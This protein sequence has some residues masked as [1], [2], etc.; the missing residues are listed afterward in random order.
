MARFDENTAALRQS[1]L[2]PIVDEV[3]AR[4]G[5]AYRLS[6]TA[7]AGDLNLTDAQGN[8]LYAPD[9]LTFS[10]HQVERFCAAP[11]RLLID[12]PQP[13]PRDNLIAEEFIRTLYTGIGSAEIN[14]TP[15]PDGGALAVF[16]MGLGVH[17]ALLLDRLPVKDVVLYE[18]DPNMLYWS[19]HV[20]PWAGLIEKITAR[21]GGLRIVGLPQ[22]EHAASEIIFTLRGDNAALVDGSYLYTHLESPLNAAV[23]SMVEQRARFLGAASG[24]VEDEIVM[25]RNTAENL[26]RYRWRIV[27]DH[28]ER[29]DTGAVAVAVGSGPSFDKAVRTLRE[30]KGKAT[31]FSA[32]SAL[33]G[34]LANGIRPDFHCELENDDAAFI[35]LTETAKD[36]DLGGIRLVGGDAVDPRVGAFFDSRYLFFRPGTT[37][38]R[39]FS[40]GHPALSFSSPTVTNVAAR[41]A[42]AF[43]FRTLVLAGV[44]LG[45]KD[46][47]QHHAVDSF[48]NVS[49]DEYWRSGT[50]M[51]ALA[52]QVPG[53]FGGTVYTNGNFQLAQM[54]FEKL[55]A[56]MPGAAVYNTSDGARIPG[57][58]PARLES[59]AGAIEEAARFDPDE[60]LADLPWRGGPQETGSAH[61]ALYKAALSDWFDGVERVFSGSDAASFDD[62]HTAL[63]P[64]LQSHE[65]AGEQSV[66]AAAVFCA[67]GSLS[68]CLMAGHFLIRRLNASDAGPFLGRFQTLLK[69]AVGEM[70][71]KAMAQFD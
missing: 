52:A 5:G 32:G 71:R 34:L 58:E 50:N 53:N 37:G 24:F 28:L 47:A 38:A 70:R 55:F 7:E 46:P 39:V 60:A 41:A 62:L 56:V 2:G 16:G 21:G 1:G 11:S 10:F 54:F 17:L 22:P 63:K 15:S 64:F 44:D 67:S 23:R 14:A 61:P 69:D 66:E 68:R 43:G 12:P 8:R 4:E 19:F 40:N 25:Y 59:L 27:P 42:F 31:I 3:L 18:S 20:L 6:G 13:A 33:R 30:L 48:Y 9:A 29:P 35:L 26:R 49:E 57:T 51:E 65:R 45:S 36:Y